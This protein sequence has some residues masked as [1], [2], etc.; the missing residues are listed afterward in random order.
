MLKSNFALTI[1][2]KQ[3]NNKFISLYNNFLSSKP[4]SILSKLKNKN[5]HCIVS[6]NINKDSNIDFIK[7]IQFIKN[8]QKYYFHSKMVEKETHRNLLSSAQSTEDFLKSKNIQY[9]IQ[10]HNPV[11]NMAE[12]SQIVC[13][14]EGIS[15]HYAKN[16]V[17]KSK[18][19]NFVYYLLPGEQNA[20]IK[21]LEKFS[22]EKGL[23]GANETHLHDY[24]NVQKGGVTPFGL[25]NLTEDNRSKF[26]L[27]IDERLSDREYIA[28][29]A[30]INDHTI[31]L[32][33]KDLETLLKE[34]KIN[35]K[36]FDLAKFEKELSETKLKEEEAEKNKKS[37]EVK[38]E[39]EEHKHELSIKNKKEEHTFS[40]WYSEVIT[41]SEMIEYYD[42]SGCYILRP[43]AYEIWEN[44]QSYFD[45]KIK[46]IGVKNCYFPMFVSQD[47]LEKEKDHIEGFCPEVAWVTHYGDKQLDKKVAIRPTSETIM[48]PVFSKW[49]NSHRDLPLLMNQWCNVVRWESKNPTPFVR[50]REFL[51]Q[52]GHSVH[53]TEDQADSFMLEILE[54]YRQVFEELL[55]IPVVKGMKSENEKFAGAL[56]TSSL[57]TLIPANGKAIQCATSHNLGQNFAKMFD[58]KFLDKNQ[59]FQYAWQESWGLSTRSIGALVMVHGDNDGLKLPPRVAPVQIVLVPIVTS[60]DKTGSVTKKLVEISEELVKRGFRIKLDDSEIHNPGFK[61]NYWE[62]KGVPLRIEF[63]KKD[64]D[65]SQVTLVPRDTKIKFTCSFDEL[66]DVCDKTLEEIQKRMFDKAN[67]LF[68]GH[69]GEAKDFEEFSKHL[70]AKNCILAPWCTNVKCEDEVKEKVKKLAE[71]GDE[72]AGTV[73]TLN[74]PLVQKEITENDKCFNCGQPAKKFTL[75]GRSY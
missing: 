61:Y 28:V 25:L 6:N 18:N 24:L 4:L 69:R 37:K 42:V 1:L 64:L 58:I 65:K 12:L 11:M 22:G 9:H 16:M 47:C 5:M 62:L 70:N 36:R 21:M 43:W 20:N 41:K 66:Y 29:H 10:S 72:N 52:E 46:S 19:G 50:T 38:G 7:H 30:M 68:L 44:I 56:R 32:H 40:D 2:L 15:F 3:N 8:Q 14:K 74:I 71:E 55:A 34:N 39:P 45:K 23:Q 26:T 31:W 49:I 48:Y 67:E 60:N 35:V 13:T 33:F 57:E 17:F 53:E 27:V 54:F 73:K 59:K 51:W 63:G 75:W